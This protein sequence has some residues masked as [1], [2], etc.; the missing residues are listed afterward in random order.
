MLSL[1][2]DS[3]LFGRLDD[4]LKSAGALEE[5][6]KRLKHEGRVEL[7]NYVGGFKASVDIDIGKF[8]AKVWHL[9]GDL[10]RDVLH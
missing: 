6:A 9:Q 2:L 5:A 10:P 4:P 3:S 7:W 1:R 8:I